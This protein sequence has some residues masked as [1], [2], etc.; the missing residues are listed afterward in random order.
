MSIMEGGYFGLDLA[1][2]YLRR[3]QSPSGIVAGVS[4]REHAVETFTRPKM[5][6]SGQENLS[7]F[8]RGKKVS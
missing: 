6:S 4:S 3:L 5:L 8:Q 1:I 2:E 7:A